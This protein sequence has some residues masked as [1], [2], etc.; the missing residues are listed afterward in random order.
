MRYC[1]GDKIICRI[2]ENG[3]FELD[4]NFDDA[5]FRDYDQATLEVI[6][7][8]DDV[9]IV[10]APLRCETYFLMRED[11]VESYGASSHYIGKNITF[12]KERA[13]GG[14]ETFD[15]YLNPLRC[16]VC[17]EYFPWAIPNQNDGRFPCFVCRDDS[18]NHIVY[19]IRK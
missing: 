14:I 13:V 18:R 15:P 16:C 2:S 4:S 10:E 12:V 7:I 6:G 1:I 5:R 9:Y 17:R 3:I 11:Y 19:K 8:S